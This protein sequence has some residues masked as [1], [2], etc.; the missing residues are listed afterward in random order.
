LDEIRH[1][2]AESHA[3]DEKTSKLKPEV[4]FQYGGRLFSETGNSNILGHGLS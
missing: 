3:D 1:A 4:Q 2:D